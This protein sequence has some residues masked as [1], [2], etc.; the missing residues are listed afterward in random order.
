MPLFE[1]H[2]SITAFI[3]CWQSKY[4]IFIWFS[5]DHNNYLCNHTVN[6]FD[7]GHRLYIS[8]SCL[9][10]INSRINTNYLDQLG[11]KKQMSFFNTIHHNCMLVHL[12]CTPLL[13]WEQRSNQSREIQLLLATGNE[14]TVTEQTC[15]LARLPQDKNL[16]FTGDQLIGANTVLIN[17]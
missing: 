5:C 13:T 1:L 3:F 14:Q 16:S 17:G 11:Y 12:L 8:T 6:Q 4:K 9:S 15:P 7:Y 2:W 10:K